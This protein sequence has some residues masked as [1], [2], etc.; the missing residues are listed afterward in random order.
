MHASI[1]ILRGGCAQYHSCLLVCCSRY[2][3][4]KL[5]GCPDAIVDNIRT[6]I[7]INFFFRQ[8]EY[9]LHD[10]DYGEVRGEAFEKNIIVNDTVAVN[11]VNK[12]FAN[13][14]EFPL[15]VVAKR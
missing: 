2:I 12:L 1:R 6:I 8:E 5:S 14:H 15:D 3:L 10:L 13:P 7:L 4:I 11:L 9:Q